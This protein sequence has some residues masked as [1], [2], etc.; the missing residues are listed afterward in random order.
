MGGGAGRGDQGVGNG[1][2]WPLDEFK[3]EVLAGRAEEDRASQS[4]RGS[5]VLRRKQSTVQTAGHRSSVKSHV[6]MD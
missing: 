5:L 6:R 1:E 4:I 3:L 2:H